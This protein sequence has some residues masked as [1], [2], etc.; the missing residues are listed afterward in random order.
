MNIETG[1]CLLLE[2][3]KDEDI[4]GKKKKQPKKPAFGM[5]RSHSHGFIEHWKLAR[6][7]PS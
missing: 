5:A 4:N 1:A 3:I 6:L 2:N 7:E